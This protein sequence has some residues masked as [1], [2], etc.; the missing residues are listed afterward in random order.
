MADKVDDVRA[1]FFPK[2]FRKMFSRGPNTTT[3]AS[4]S[5]VVVRARRAHRRR[6]AAT[7]RLNRVRV[8][9]P[10]GLSPAKTRFAVLD[11]ED[12]VK[13]DGHA[14]ALSRLLG[15]AGETWE[16]HRC[17]SGELPD[18]REM[19]TY[20]G[21]VVTG[22]HYGVRDEHTHPWIGALKRF[23]AKVVVH[24]GVKVYGACFG[25]QVIAEALGGKVAPNPCGVPFVLKRETVVLTEAMTDRP[26][27]ETALASFPPT[28]LGRASEPPKDC[29]KSKRVAKLAVL[30]AHG[31]C[32]VTLPNDAVL[33]G[34]SETAPCEIFALG[35]E[36]LAVQGHPELD[37]SS[38]LANIA[39]FVHALSDD[40]RAAAKSSLRLETDHVTL[41]GI[42]RAFLRGEGAKK[43]DAH[44]DASVFGAERGTERTR[45]HGKDTL[46]A[47]RRHAEA[48]RAALS[49]TAPPRGEAAA[50]K[51]PDSAA[52]TGSTSSATSNVA[53]AAGAASVAANADSAAAR[54]AASFAPPLDAR[55]AAR[56]LCVAAED[57]F[58]SAAHAAKDEVR[59]VSHEFSTLARL[60]ASASAKYADLGATV[61]GLGVFADALR[62]KDA[63]AAPRFADLDE[64]ER[65]LDALEEAAGALEA[66]A[67]RLENRARAVRA[68]ALTR[69][70]TG[71]RIAG[72]EGVILDA[73]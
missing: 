20:Q 36:V 24:G 37:G 47:L 65:N 3:G 7:P 70:A 5:E 42:V 22:S 35:E 43:R 4:L 69:R 71:Q 53:T 59:A 6:C 21:L 40:D 27:Y 9:P 34:S 64:V 1:S 60:N 73:S 14:I 61:A 54:S 8:M 32:V 58:V 51:R 44:E 17:W 16:H 11:C 72:G 62:R 18:L 29:Q 30:Q 33:L 41:V 39:P 13:W 56:E 38:M 23:I 55:L 52:L 67:D 15:R 10:A 28:A 49:D 31:D 46:D 26:E 68:L 45:K 66:E 50:A 19:H 57:A 12:A 25:C 63:N 48:A 2:V